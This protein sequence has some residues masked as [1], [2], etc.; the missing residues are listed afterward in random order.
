MVLS[1]GGPVS[2]R[3]SPYFATPKLADAPSHATEPQSRIAPP[4][5][6]R[7]SGITAWAKSA[8]AFR[9]PAVKLDRQSASL[10]SR[11]DERRP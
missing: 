2:A 5:R 8:G 7:I 10:A 6:R 3:K 1:T 11:P 4:P 9:L